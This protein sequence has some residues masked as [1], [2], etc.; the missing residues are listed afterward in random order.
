[1]PPALQ[2]HILIIVDMTQVSELSSVCILPYC[3][4]DKIKIINQGLHL[5][6]TMNKQI[7]MYK[8]TID[9][10]FL[11]SYYDLCQ[12]DKYSNLFCMSVTRLWHS[13]DRS[14]A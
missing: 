14:P 11:I 10:Y 6:Y 2:N 3:L 13:L 9:S 7:N 12:F 4:C 8:T 5:S 1:M